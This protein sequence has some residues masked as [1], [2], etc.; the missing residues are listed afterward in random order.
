MRFL[1]I[2]SYCFKRHSSNRAV[3]LDGM[4]VAQLRGVRAGFDD[5]MEAELEELLGN[6]T[7][8]IDFTGYYHIAHYQLSPREPLLR[9]LIPAGTQLV[10]GEIELQAA[11]L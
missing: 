5:P 4:V 11:V 9:H 2:M 7:A 8:P 1:N 3:L 6:S 10:A